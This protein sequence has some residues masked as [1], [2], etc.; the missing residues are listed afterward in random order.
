MTPMFGYPFPETR[1][2][3][4]TEQRKGSFPCEYDDAL[5]IFSQLNFHIPMDEVENGVRYTKSR[6]FEE[7]SEENVPYVRGL[8]TEVGPG[9]ATVSFPL[10]AGKVDLE[11]YTRRLFCDDGSGGSGGQE[12]IAAHLCSVGE[13]TTCFDADATI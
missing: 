1:N 12:F 8:V 6:W 11:L 2:I 3:R 9:L 4:E 5:G 10:P 7:F 13:W